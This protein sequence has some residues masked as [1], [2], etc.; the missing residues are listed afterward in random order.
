MTEETLTVTDAINEY[1]K[2][3]DKY[4]TTYYE[5]Y[6][7][8]IVTSTQDKKAKRNSYARL[9]KAE[10]I[11]CKRNVGT[12][13]NVSV[14]KEDLLR[15]FIVKCGDQVDPCPLD[16]SIQTSDRGQYD[17]LISQWTGKLNDTKKDIIKAKNDVMFFSSDATTATTKFEE[18][19]TKIKDV[20]D[21]L[22]YIVEHDILLNDSPVKAEVLKKEQD[23][24]GK[25]FIL[26]FKQMI[27]EFKEG[28]ELILNEA[29]SFYVNELLPKTKQI[30][31]LKYEINEID[32]DNVT[33]KYHLYQRKNSLNNLT[34]F[35]GQD[36]KVISFKKGI[37]KQPKEKTRKLKEG[38]EKA[39]TRK[40]RGMIEL[41]EEEEPGVEPE[42][43][44]VQGEPNI[45]NMSLN[46][47]KEVNPDIPV[48]KIVPFV[49]PDAMKGNV[50]TDIY[51]VQLVKGG[52]AVVTVIEAGQ[53]KPSGYHVSWE[54]ERELLN[55]LRTKHSYSAI[56]CIWY[57]VDTQFGITESPKKGIDKGK[58]VETA[59]RGIAEET[60]LFIPSYYFRR[61]GEVFISDKIRGVKNIAMFTVDIDRVE[62]IEYDYN[63]YDEYEDDKS[64]TAVK[65]FVILLGDQQRLVEL[66]T[67]SRPTEKMEG[68]HIIPV[69]SPVLD[70]LVSRS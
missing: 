33:G 38:I 31:E 39:K 4:E 67:K 11:N 14:S 18:L 61:F 57:G 1:Y 58:P 64:E 56:A 54:K 20:T 23:E 34:M 52:N 37:K 29:E 63:D 48:E 59:A 65:A 44:Q 24:F 13:F 35:Y 15:K 70:T 60:S 40:V 26:P 10:C 43:E 30:R 8:P 62:D 55:Y 27:E 12:I 2:M 50:P 21:Q 19:T 45:D 28:N 41:V 69:M 68:Y 17:T 46:E 25:G 47:I 3:K 16:I 22:G 6:V 53:V 32:Y 7:K 49:K 66:L 9:P 42:P 5:K 51:Q 36:D